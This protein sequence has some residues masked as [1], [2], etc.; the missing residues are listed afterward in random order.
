MTIAS[1]IATKQQQVA[2][3]YTIISNK[4]GTLP[5]T[6]NLTNLATAI[7]SIPSGDT[8]DIEEA[9]HNIN[10][11][12]G[13]VTEKCIAWVVTNG[14]ILNDNTSWA[15]TA[16]ITDGV[17]I[18]QFINNSYEYIGTLK[19]ANE[20][21][22]YLEEYNQRITPF[23]EVYANTDASQIY[24]VSEWTIVDNGGVVYTSK[25][26][27]TGTGFWLNYSGASL[28]NFTPGF[29]YYT[30]GQKYYAKNASTGDLIEITKVGD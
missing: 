2:D 30:D 21:E 8:T 25:N 23:M 3:S 4:G 29:Y 24:E 20:G 28:S 9:L 19:V 26:P 1:A 13:A 6:Q 12:G 11:G 15:Y 7:S 5:Q 18:N 16:S 10:S 17:P 27:I 22:Y 14:V